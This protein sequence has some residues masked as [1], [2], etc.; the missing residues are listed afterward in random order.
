M[1]RL[2]M[3]V[4]GQ[5]EEAF[6]H[7]VLEAPLAQREIF[8][9]VRCAETSRDRK[10][11]QVY[12]GGL[13][14]YSR[15]RGDLWR[16]M[17]EDQHPEAWF[18]TMFDLYGLP[19]DFPAYE[20]ARKLANPRERVIALESAF[21]QDINHPRFVPYLQLHEFEALLLADPSK[22]D[23][24]FIEHTPAIT[25]LVSLAAQYASPEQIDDGADTAPSKRI[26]REIPE[27]EFRKAS[28]GPIIAS[29][30]GLP[31]L[32]QKCMHFHEWME[33]LEALA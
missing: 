28:A 29:K 26:I 14:D 21:R 33:K 6:A 3:I 27:Y 17:K 30:I 25:R 23:W 5:T 9:S 19:D 7:A 4:E 16:W 11:H 10:Q 22:F 15:A 32:R 12:R 18:T 13:I 31:V 20:T 1:I 24:E 2:N 8:V